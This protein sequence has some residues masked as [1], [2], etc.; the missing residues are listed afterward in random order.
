M[1]PDVLDDFIAANVSQG[2][3][4]KWLMTKTRRQRAMSDTESIASDNGM[5]NYNLFIRIFMSYIQV[6]VILFSY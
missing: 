4:E 2:Q 1:N 5:Q 6:N 3:L